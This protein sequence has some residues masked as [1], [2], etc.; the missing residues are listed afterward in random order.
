MGPF[1]LVDPLLNAHMVASVHRYHATTYADWPSMTYDPAAGLD[2][3][4][5]AIDGRRGCDA[6]E[7]RT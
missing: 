6:A 3:G 4:D 1:N 5:S 7:G 2:S